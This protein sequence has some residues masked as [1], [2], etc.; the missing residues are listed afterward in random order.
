VKCRGEKIVQTS[1]C[2]SSGLD[3]M[4]KGREVESELK[5]EPDERW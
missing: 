2:S 3:E 4:E 1:A 5:R